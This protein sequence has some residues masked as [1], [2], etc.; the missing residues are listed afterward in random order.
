MA[1]KYLV[2]SPGRSGSI[3][4][5]LTIARSLGLKAIMSTQTPLPKTDEPLVYHSHDAQLQLLDQDIQVIHVTRR[6]LFN[7]IISA[8]MCEQYNE[9][10][11]YSGLGQ[12]FVADLNVFENKYHWHK[13]WHRAHHSLTRYQNRRYLTFENFIGRSEVICRELNIPSVTDVYTQKNPY[14]SSNIL[15][16]YDLSQ[17][18]LQLESTAQPARN[19]EHWTDQRSK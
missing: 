10:Y 18:F 12:P 19:A 15:N 8:V 14:L 2:C 9:W 16:I 1:V 13:Y 3:F 11:N 17:R 5:T 7:E 6:D 4:V